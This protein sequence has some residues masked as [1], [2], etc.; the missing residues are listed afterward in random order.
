MPQTALLGPTGQASQSEKKSANKTEA[1]DKLDSALEK[2]QELLA[3]FEK[4]SD[5]LNAVLSNLEGSTLVKRLKAASREQNLVAEKI[6]TRIGKVFGQAAQVASEDRTFLNELSETERASGLLISYIMDDIQAFY[7]RRRTNEFKR[8]LDEMKS[9]DIVV[10]IQNLAEELAAEHGLSIATAEYWADN[11]DRWAEDLVESTDQSEEEKQEQKPGEESQ[12]L[13]PSLILEML[14]ILESEVN[15]REQTRIAQQAVTAIEATDHIQQ[16]QGLSGQQADLRVRTEEVSDQI[17]KLP[18]ADQ[19]FAQELSILSQ[20]SL[21]MDQARELLALGNTGPEA[22]AAETEVIELMLQSKRIN[23]QGAGSG[24]GG[25][26]PGGGG[27][28]TTSESALALIGAGLNS[29]EHR[30]PRDIGQAV[31]SSADRNLPE[32]FRGGLDAY[33]QQL[34]TAP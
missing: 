3:E 23:P 6:A 17:A 11:L 16:A 15:L 2:Q 31:G 20:V 12:S 34:E 18:D 10:A 24:G 19:H 7:Q 29:Q 1:T 9:S 32:E 26:S 13:P 4:L 21:I 14:K 25:A 8:V 30:E 33:F 27:L 5:E 28:G 22:I